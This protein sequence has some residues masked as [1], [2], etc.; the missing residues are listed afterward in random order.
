MPFV[1][2]QTLCWDCKKSC[3][4]CSWSN[5]WEHTPVPGWKAKKTSVRLN[6]SEYGESYIV[7]KCP[8]F[9]ADAKGSGKVRL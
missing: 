4:D 6:N 3:G 5:H 2:E 8:E 1:K 9:E 7:Q